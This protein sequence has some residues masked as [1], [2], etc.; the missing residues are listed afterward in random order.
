[1]FSGTAASPPAKLRCPQN[2]HIALGGS[3]WELEIAIEN[4]CEA[5]AYAGATT[6]YAR[7]KLRNICDWAQRCIGTLS[8]PNLRRR[9]RNEPSSFTQLSQTSCKTA[10]SVTLTDGKRFN[11]STHR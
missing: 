9:A 8:Q 11:N 4:L 5:S 6:L 2:P 7:A 1:M 10:R 3:R